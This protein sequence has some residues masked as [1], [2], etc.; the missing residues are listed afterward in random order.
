MFGLDFVL[1]Q[2]RSPDTQEQDA[3]DHG[4]GG[5]AGTGGGLSFFDFADAC[6]AAVAFQ[7]QAGEPRDG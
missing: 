6:Q 7:S 2:E 1:A 5:V 3:A 4:I